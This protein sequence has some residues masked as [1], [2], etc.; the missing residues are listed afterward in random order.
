MVNHVFVLTTTKEGE[1][2]KNKDHIDEFVCIINA[3]CYLLNA[4]C[5]MLLTKCYLLDAECLLLKSNCKLN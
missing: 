4:F 5:K 2:G 1:K 3:K